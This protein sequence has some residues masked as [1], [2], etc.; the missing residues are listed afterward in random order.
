MMTF[1]LYDTLT[2]PGTPAIKLQELFFFSCITNYIDIQFFP[3]DKWTVF[4]TGERAVTEV[5]TI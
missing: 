4:D 1:G 3:Q 2:F 5:K